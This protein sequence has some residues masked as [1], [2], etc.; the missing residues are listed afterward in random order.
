MDSL[1]FILHVFAH[2]Y[3]VQLHVEGESGTTA[4]RSSQISHVR[5]IKLHGQ[6]LIIPEVSERPTIIITTSRWERKA[7]TF[8][9]QSREYTAAK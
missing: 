4:S 3:S 2:L 5:K 8:G 9:M 1:F 7:L 6:F